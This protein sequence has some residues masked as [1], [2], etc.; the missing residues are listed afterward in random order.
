MRVKKKVVFSNVSLEEKVKLKDSGRPAP[1]LNIVQEQKEC[2]SRPGFKRK[3]DKTFM[4]RIRGCADVTK[5][6]LFFVLFAYYLEAME[7][8]QR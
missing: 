1:I 6:M 7:F 2:K 8:G 4:R 5:A 3:F